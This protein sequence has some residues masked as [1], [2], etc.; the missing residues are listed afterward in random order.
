MPVDEDF[1][2]LMQLNLGV[3][4]ILMGSG[5]DDKSPGEDEEGKS[6]PS[7]IEKIVTSLEAYEVPYDVRVC[8]AHKQPVPL[9]KIIDEYDAVGGSVAYIAVAGGTD[10]LSGT[11]SFHACGIVFSC[12][13]DAPNESCTTNPPGSPSAYV[14]RPENV[15]KAVAQAFAGINTKYKQLLEEK[16]AAKIASL[17]KDDERIHA[18]YKARMQEKLGGK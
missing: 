17:E 8:S 9:K 2:K 6:K 15:G 18:K 3:A 13:P 5:S 16:N 11:D 1:K 7:H 12:P 10:A 14:P 4:V